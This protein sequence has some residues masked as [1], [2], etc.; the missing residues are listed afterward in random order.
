MK[1]PRMSRIRFR[2]PHDLLVAFLALLLPAWAYV[3]APE[4]LKLPGDFSYK[5]D[6]VS[7]DDF[8]DEAA[9]DFR[10][11]Q[12]SK[13]D[14]SYRVVAHDGDRLTIRNVFDVRTQAGEPIFRTERLY[15]ID[16]R[17]GMHL[18]GLGDEERQ[19][20]LF[21]P[22]G[23][24]RGEPFTYW[25]VNYDG[26]AHMTFVQ[27]ETLYGLKV[28]VYETRYEGV[29]ID[30]TKDLGFLPGVGVTRGVELDPHLRLWVEPTT[31]RVVKHEDETTAYFYDLTT[32]ERL[33][34]WNRFKNTYVEESLPDIVASIKALKYRTWAVE[35]GGPILIALALVM[36]LAWRLGFSRMFRNVLSG[37]LIAVGAL[38]L[39]LSL[40]IAGFL[41]VRAAVD[42]S[43][44]KGLEEESRQLD[45]L[46]Q[47]RL[48]IYANLLSGARGLF[49]ASQSVSRSEWKAYIDALQVQK[50]YPGIQG[51]GFTKVVRPEALDALVDEVRT[52]GFPDFKVMPEGER[53]VYSSII[54]L[55]PFDE[56][57]RRAFGFDML[58][59]PTRRR[60]MLAAAETG[61]PTA[62]AKVTLLQEK[63]TDVQ[64]GFLMYV[65]VYRNGSVTTSAENRLDSL[66]GYV[67]AA[68]RMNDLMRGILGDRD[69]NLDIEVYD[70][71]R[72][73]SSARMYASAGIEGTPD[74]QVIFKRFQTLYVAG[75]PWTVEFVNRPGVRSDLLSR[76]L[77]WVALAAGSLVSTLIFLVILSFARSRNLAVAYADRVTL[78]LKKSVADLE[79][80]KKAILNILEDV[81]EEKDKAE[82]IRRRL[83]LATQG[84]KIGVWEWDVK[85]DVLIWDDQMFALYGVAKEKFGGAYEAWRSGLHPDDVKSG[86]EAIQ[87]ALKGEKEFDTDFRVVWPN[88]DVHYIQARALVERAPDGA[89][90][91]MVGVNW[92]V[93]HEKIVDL[94][95]TEFV[96]LAAHQLQTPVGSL[97]WNIEMLLD[98]DYGA[99]KA[100]QK[101]VLD[102]MYRMNRRMRDLINSLLNVSRI[103]LGV[104]L[105]EPV[106]TDVRAVCEEVLE[107]MRA[108]I[109]EKGMTV[110]RNLDPD[111]GAYSADP[112]LLR[113]IFQNF[114]SNAVKYSPQGGRVDVEVLKKD[115]DVLIAV[116]NAGPGIPIEDQPNIFKKLYRASNAMK[117]DAD[118]NGLGLYIVKKIAENAGG[119]TWFTS[120]PGERTVFYASF[121]L[122]GMLKHEGTKALS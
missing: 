68:F 104:F 27:E 120:V 54:Y 62:S 51:I 63:E 38:A 81:K 46:I 114:V 25:H 66:D 72:H 59:E 101:E 107:E 112:K 6:I 97:N 41:A 94:E 22:R 99:L 53:D 88:G 117:L 116:A 40:T 24:K 86:D 84:A 61:V 80:T 5:A 79:K 13:T 83:A 78:D 111:L 19:G 45:D 118:G 74:D 33:H 23:L 43:F 48:D 90:L 102:S 60:A 29:R 50:N 7:V 56:R 89:P 122:T 31:G 105:I 11:E 73:E 35:Y 15:G 67:Y 16:A 32:H 76:S 98:G 9:G 85:K 12:F 8:Y 109:E 65:A 95:K 28:F 113:M 70:G 87:R 91:K 77:P 64:A 106:P 10:G 103:D 26:P 52:D 4:L 14:F 121:P 55:E 119:K 39:M 37:R 110:E 93:T 18:A 30:Q 92:D 100:A 17:T 71:L 47:K 21:A 57:N 2:A 42:R 20:Y 108:R 36:L 1:I 115:G 58:S 96:S 3:I 69:R 75:R 44:A 82:Q 49:A 34:P